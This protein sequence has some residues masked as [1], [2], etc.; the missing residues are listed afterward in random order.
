MEGIGHCVGALWPGW[1]EVVTEIL[2]KQRIPQEIDGPKVGRD[3]PQEAALLATGKSLLVE[4]EAWLGHAPSV[5]R[6]D[7]GIAPGMAGQDIGERAVCMLHRN[8][9]DQSART[10][11]G[12]LS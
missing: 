12:G 2:I 8:V 10:G 1:Q 3:L 6:L 4:R 7:V 5:D 11:G 9:S